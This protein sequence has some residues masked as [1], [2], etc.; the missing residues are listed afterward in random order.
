MQTDMMRRVRKDM[1]VVDL[2]GDK[3]GS[4]DEV[5]SSY[6]K[7]NTGF[8]GLGK[9]YYVPFTAM[10]DVRQD[11]VVLSCDK[12]RLDSMGWDS[13]PRAGSTGRW[14]DD[15]GYYRTQWQQRHGTTGGRWEDHEPYYRYGWET[16]QRPEYR[17]R[18]WDEAEPEVRRDWEA[19]YR[20][21]PWTD[22]REH[23]RGTW[24]D[25]EGDRTVQLREEEM[26]ARKQ[27]REAGDVT[28]RKDVVTEQRT[29]EVPVTHEEVTIERHPVDRK[30]A[31]R[32][33]NEGETIRVPVREEE[34]TIEKR[35]VVREEV[36]IGKRARQDTKEV[37]GTVR[38]EEVEINPE[39]DV[40]TYDADSSDRRRP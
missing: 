25:T 39:G 29:M 33:I 11:T 38:R 18:S 1:D 5:Q 9:D 32:P 24:D 37:S 3:I 30:P 12:D 31:D 19:R 28:L 34:V 22:A 27:T 14:E 17:G 20:D 6:A 2:D 10:Q 13:P 7:I 36:T 23:V 15:Q 40:R 35:P 8:L 26:V 4:V 16:R 21:R